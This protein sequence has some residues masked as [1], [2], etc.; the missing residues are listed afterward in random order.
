MHGGHHAAI[1]FIAGLMHARRINQNDLSVGLRDD[2][3][4]FEAS[5]LWLVRDGRDLFTD[6]PV[7]KR[8][9]ARVGPANQGDKTG[10]EGL[11]RITNLLS[12][13]VVGYITARLLARVY[14]HSYR[15]RAQPC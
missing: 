12:S 6:Q 3:Q 5:C 10:A 8:R 11:H 2:A 9:L 13:H 4:D 15:K 14:D 1:E 7:Q